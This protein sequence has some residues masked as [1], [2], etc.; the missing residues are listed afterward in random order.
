MR[1]HEQCGLVIAAIKEKGQISRQIDE[2]TD[3]VN[4]IQSLIN[5]QIFRSKLSHKS[6]WIPNLKDY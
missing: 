5:Q 1:L 4:C 2:L 3:E 6:Q